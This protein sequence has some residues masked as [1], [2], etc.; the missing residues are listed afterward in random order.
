VL[1]WNTVDDTVV[2]VDSD[3]DTVSKVKNT[4]LP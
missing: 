4:N 3:S 2:N 1:D